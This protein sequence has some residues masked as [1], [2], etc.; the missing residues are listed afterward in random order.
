MKQIKR[1]GIHPFN[2][3]TISSPCFNFYAHFR[4]VS[5][6]TFWEQKIY[7]HIDRVSLFWWQRI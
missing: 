6:E 5:Y 3:H 1:F 4:N 2:V 7:R